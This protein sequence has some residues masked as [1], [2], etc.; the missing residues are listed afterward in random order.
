V[1]DDRAK[2]FLQH[3]TAEPDDDTPRLIYADWLEEHGDADRAEFIRVQIERTSLPKW[4]ARQVRLRLREREL[5][6]LH[7]GRW[8]AELPDIKGV[9]WDEFRRGFVATAA[10]ARV[11]VL[12][13]RADE[14]WAAA[15][16]EAV[17]VPWPRK[18]ERCHTIAPIAGLR[19]LLICGSLG[20]PAEVGQLANAPLLSTLRVLAIPK[21]NLG[22]AAF[23]LL[24]SSP[25]LGSL[26][27]LRLPG[28]AIGN[29]GVDALTGAASLDS[30][31]ELDLSE[32]DSYSSYGEDPII[33]ALGAEA[34]AGWPGMGRI[35]SLNLSGSSF[36]QDGLRALLRSPHATG[37]KELALGRNDLFGQAMEEFEAA[38]TELRLEVLD[39]SENPIGDLGAAHL[40]RADCLRELKALELDICDMSPSAAH[41][42]AGAPVLAGLRRLSANNNNFRSEGLQA[43][44]DGGPQELHTL[45][46]VNNGIDNEGVADLAESPASDTLLELDLGHNDVGNRAARALARSKHLRNLLILGLT[47][48][49]IEKRGEAALRAS[50]LGKRL[51]VLNLGTRPDDEEIPF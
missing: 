39:L 47:A 14:C 32:M 13:E 48:S 33:E 38:R 7:K 1:S 44:L 34:L 46:L 41:R 8:M 27:A 40:A 28:N 15:P 5:L 4:D 20:D 22:A 49:Y 12:R 42:L 9:V 19:E 11:T 6:A 21:A 36:G 26:K 10:F 50:E 35:R 25:H 45:L 31:E 51:A 17:S 3:I 2:G 16:I 29:G 37:L 23:V 18:R 30:L 24:T 43:L